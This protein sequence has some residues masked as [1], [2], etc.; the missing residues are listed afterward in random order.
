MGKIRWAIAKAL[1]RILRPVALNN[2]RIDKSSRLCPGCELTSVTMDRYSYMGSNCFAVNSSIGSFCSIADACRVGGA[3]HP[4]N[5]VSSSPVFHKG[6]NILK[7]N[8]SALEPM[9]TPITTI[10]DDVWLGAGCY[11]KSG[12]TVHTGAVIGM[13][14]VVTHDVP[15]YEIWAGNPARRIRKRFDDETIERLLKI[16]WWNWDEKKISKYT[17][18]FDDPQHLFEK[19][20]EEL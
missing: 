18:Y 4:I 6:R 1:K 9:A 8:F 5:R 20:Q 7:K 12:V 19:L 14:S 16:R 3:I 17:P 2:C 10:E 13:G 11:I 15:P